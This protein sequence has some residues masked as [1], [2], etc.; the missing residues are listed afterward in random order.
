MPNRVH[1]DAGIT[2]ALATMPI[3]CGLVMALMPERFTAASW[4]FAMGMPGGY[5]TWAGLLIVAGLSMV[6]GLIHHDPTHEHRHALW[7]TGMLLAGAWWILLAAVFFF[8]SIFDPK[9]NPIGVVPWG[10]IGVL[11]LWWTWFERRRWV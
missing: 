9:A 6:I 5:A 10:F 8:T 11:Y 4:R 3:P 1:R 7:V 2:W